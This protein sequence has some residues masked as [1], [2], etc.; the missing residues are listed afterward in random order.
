MEPMLNIALCAARSAATLIERAWGRTDVLNFEEKGRNDFV[1]EVDKASE[2]ELIF[3]LRKAYKET[4]RLR[5]R[6]P[7]C[8]A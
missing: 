2:Q 8:K 3:H 7:I 4:R 5:S 6:L 1:T